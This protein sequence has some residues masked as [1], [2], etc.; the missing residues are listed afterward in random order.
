M[1]SW[2]NHTWQ[3]QKLKSIISSRASQYSH[4]AKRKEREAA[5]LKERLSQL[6]VDRKDKKLGEHAINQN[7]FHTLFV[8]KSI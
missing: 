8:F 7:D 5:K 3:V 2:F 4:D 6:L 1:S